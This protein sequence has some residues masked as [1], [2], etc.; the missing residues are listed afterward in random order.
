MP[1]RRVRTYVYPDGLSAPAPRPP[2]NRCRVLIII[3]NA[4]LQAAAWN[5][6]ARARR[7][8]EKAAHE[9]HRHEE[10][11]TPAF[12]AWLAQ[13]FP[14]LLSTV[15]ELAQQVAAKMQLVQSVETESLLTGRP[16]GR[17]WRAWQE[18]SAQRPE[19][20]APEPFDPTQRSSDEESGEPDLGKAFEEEM[21]RMFDRHGVMDDDPFADDFRDFARG[22]FGLGEPRLDARAA[23]DAREIYRRLVR[24][25]H[26]DSGGDWTPA[27]ARLWEQVQEA[28]TARDG[29]WLARLEA[30]WEVQADRLGPTSPVS[31]LR[32]AVIEIEAARRDAE[33]RVRQYRRDDA[34]R[35]SLR[36]ATTELRIRTQEKLRHD[37]ALLRDQ[38]AELEAL[39]ARWERSGRRRRSVK[40]HVRA[41]QFNLF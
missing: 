6:L 16:P 10:I 31:R 11:D 12:R 1:R 37:E 28:W 27:R 35:F 20:P 13:T 8:L 30:E 19:T 38:L 40:N 7:R 29:D 36:P 15:R 33:K 26:P 21:K 14:V 34:W 17:I 25:L 3:D 4:P 18:N 39:I 24:H 32:S 2:R 5:E 23:A 9:V 22:V 41:P